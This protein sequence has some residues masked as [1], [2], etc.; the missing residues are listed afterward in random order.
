V[1][2]FY[3]DMTATDNRG[4]A[5]S[6]VVIAG[7]KV[8]VKG[9]LQDGKPIAYQLSMDNDTAGDPYIGRRVQQTLH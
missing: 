4:Q 3:S 1:C 2:F 8:Y 5:V 7:R 9:V 6:E